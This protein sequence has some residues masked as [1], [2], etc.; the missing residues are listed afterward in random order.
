[1]FVFWKIWRPLFFSFEIDILR[2]VWDSPFWLI[3]KNCLRVF[4]SLFLYHLINCLSQTNYYFTDFNFQI[5]LAIFGN[6][7]NF[8]VD[9]RLEGLIR[10]TKMWMALTFLLKQSRFRIEYWWL[11]WTFYIPSRHSH[12]QSYQ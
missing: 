1:M 6:A 11:L 3:T 5:Y 2:F 12:V 8:V 10:S 9:F 7:P 4:F